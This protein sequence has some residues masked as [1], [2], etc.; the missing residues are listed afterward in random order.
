MGHGGIRVKITSDYGQ[1]TIVRYGSDPKRSHI[2]LISITMNLAA[3]MQSV[4]EADHMV[5]GKELY[6]RLDH[7]KQQIIFEKLDSGK[8]DWNYHASDGREP[9]QL[10]VTNF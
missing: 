10:Y 2:D 1:H 8:I 5:I 4:T 9:Y 3:K 7:H 6:H